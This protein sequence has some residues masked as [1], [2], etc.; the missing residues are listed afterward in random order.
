MSLNKLGCLNVCVCHSY[1][2]VVKGNGALPPEDRL[3]KFLVDN[4]GDA[5]ETVQC[6]NCDQESNKKVQ[7]DRQMD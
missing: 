7:T 1:S 4:N 6:A 2:S 5:E 3:L